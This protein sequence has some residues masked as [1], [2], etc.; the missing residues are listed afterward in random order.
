MMKFAPI[1]LLLATAAAFSASPRSARS[2]A[3]QGV[4]PAL[5]K[6]Q[7]GRARLSVR[8]GSTAPMMNALSAPAQAFAAWYMRC[9][10]SAPVPTKSVTFFF[11]SALGDLL[12]QTIQA[13]GVAGGLSLNWHRLRV[14]AV[15]GAVYVAPVIHVWFGY[16]ERL[17]SPGGPLAS[18]PGWKAVA[19]M[20]FIDQTVGATIVLSSIYVVFELLDTAMKMQ[21]FSVPAAFASGVTKL[22]REFKPTMLM[23]WRIWPL[24]NAIN[25]GLVP[26]QLR[27]LFS[28][29]ISVA[30]NAFLS[31]SM[32]R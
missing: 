21:P 32:N 25:F 31:A 12:S 18:L 19:A 15:L 10:N 6:C 23:N 1:V 16:L 8:G 3:S 28:N 9:L 29:I 22:Q 24:A 26:P 30:W 2:V 4:R 17:K 13:R 14:Y 20:T 11:I 7:Y 27:V 5:K